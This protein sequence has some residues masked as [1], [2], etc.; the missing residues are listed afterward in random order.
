MIENLKRKIEVNE[1]KKKL[2]PCNEKREMCF[3][4]KK[5]YSKKLVFFRK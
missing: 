3:Q 1:E 4:E 5:M 2:H